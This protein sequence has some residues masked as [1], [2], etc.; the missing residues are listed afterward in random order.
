VKNLLVA[1]T[2]VPLALFATAGAPAFAQYGPARPD[3]GYMPPG[4]WPVGST[5][6]AYS[7]WGAAY[8]ADDGCTYQD[9]YEKGLSDAEPH[10]VETSLVYCPPPAPKAAAVDPPPTPVTTGNGG[11]KI[12]PPPPPPPV[13]PLPPAPPAP[14]PT[15]GFI[16]GPPPAPPPEEPGLWEKFKRWCKSAAGCEDEATQKKEHDE[17]LRKAMEEHKAQ[18]GKASL[19]IKRTTDDTKT[20]RVVKQDTE[21]DS[22]NTLKANGLQAQSN[23]D[24]TGAAHF[25]RT[26][27]SIHAYPHMQKFGRVGQMSGFNAVRGGGMHMGG[28]HMGRLS[29]R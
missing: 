1:A 27:G 2:L 24:R 18:S 3:Y 15:S 11:T 16:D 7:I 26:N 13:P 9:R 8:I 14:K 10:K 23:I 21:S 5:G 28:M 6:S 12:D 25:S 29:L 17:A 22:L 4:S 20:L 19:D